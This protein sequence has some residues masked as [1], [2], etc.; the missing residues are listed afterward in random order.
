MVIYTLATVAFYLL[1]AGV[2]HAQGLVP[3]AS[4]TIQVL[5]R[6]YTGTLGEWARWPFYIGAIATL[7]GT[8]FAATAAHA[9]SFADMC[10]V[11]G[12]YNRDDY[13]TR[14]R[15]RRRFV[16]AFCILPVS[17]Y[18][19]IQSPVAMVI[20]GGV[21][22]ALMLPLIGMA[23]VYLRHCHLPKLI[24]PSRGVTVAL[25]TCTGLCLAA[26]VYSAAM[27]MGGVGRP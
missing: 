5:S 15:F 17:L 2:L 23:T 22:Q 9:R 12:L 14:L 27:T 24:A 6:L 7:Y 21:A 11:M 25:W 26:M 4:D 20:F 3:A 16:L 8:I 1:G 10:S 13:E 18:L 19:L